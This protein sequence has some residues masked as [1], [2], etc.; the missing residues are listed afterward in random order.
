MCSS[1]LEMLGRSKADAPEIDGVVY[2]ENAGHLN[3][4]DI[5]SARI[6]DADEYDLYGEPA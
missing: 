6:S 3:A 4:G 2:L 1:D 5:I